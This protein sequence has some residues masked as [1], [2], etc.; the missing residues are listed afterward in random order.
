M[1]YVQLVKRGFKYVRIMISLD[2]DQKE[3]QEIVKVTFVTADNQVTSFA[4]V[5]LYGGIL[6]ANSNKKGL[7][8]TNQTDF[9][10]T[11]FYYVVMRLVVEKNINGIQGTM[12][13]DPTN[14]ENEKV[15][16]EKLG[17]KPYYQ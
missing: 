1:K 4:N 9:R 12:N 11:A 3:A 13:N 16:I 8:Q 5:F 2:A 10:Y 6:Q 14:D 17:F 7:I 15:F